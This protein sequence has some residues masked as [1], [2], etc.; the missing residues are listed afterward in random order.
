MPKVTDQYLA[1][2]RNF[3][4]E[5]TGEILK[6][7]PLY[8]VSMRDIIKKAGFSQGAIYRYYDGLDDIYVDFINKHTTN[9]LL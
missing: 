4:I 5:C 1:D 6:E 9:I 2:K 7:K 3:I 8:Q